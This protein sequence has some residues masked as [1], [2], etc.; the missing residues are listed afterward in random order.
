[1]VDLFMIGILV[2]IVGVVIVF[3]GMQGKGKV[4]GGAVVFI[5]PLPIIGA[6]SERMFYITLA[7]SVIFIS[8][9][10]ALHLIGR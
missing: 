9:F 6:T 8:V 10:I 2:I 5:G 3:L 1:M 7:I 4:E